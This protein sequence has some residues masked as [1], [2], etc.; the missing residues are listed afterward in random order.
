MRTLSDEEV[1]G[2][3]HSPEA[4]LSDDD[5]FGPAKPAI[6]GILERLFQGASADPMSTGAAEIMAAAKP[7]PVSVLENL[8][9]DPSAFNFKA[10]SALRRKLDDGTAAPLAPRRTY[11]EASASLP[12][13]S[14]FIDNAARIARKVLGSA[15]S[16]T[17]GV[18]R[19]IGDVTGMDS[20]ADFARTSG[21]AGQRFANQTQA[22]KTQIDGFT[23]G[24]MVQ[25]VPGALEEAAVSIGTQI[26]ALATG[27]VPAAL[28][29]MF[30]QSAGTQY[31]EI[32]DKG[33][34]IAPALV[35]AAL[36][37]GAEVIG[38]KIGGTPGTL[39]ALR[40]AIT[41][42]EPARVATEMLRAGIR[43]IPGEQLTTALQYGTDAAPVIGSNLN[44]SLREYL[45]QAKKTAVQTV[46][47]GGM[48]T[49]AG[50]ALASA[51]RLAGNSPANG[52]A[53]PA[54]NSD[55]AAKEM[56]R[57]IDAAAQGIADQSPSATP[58]QKARVMDMRPMSDAEVFGE[59]KPPDAY[60]P[61]SPAIESVADANTNQAPT[62][63]VAPAEAP[64]PN[65]TPAPVQTGNEVQTSPS[66]P[67]LQAD[68]PESITSPPNEAPNV[69]NPAPAPE[70]PTQP[71]QAIA[72]QASAAQGVIAAGPPATGTP[73]RTGAVQADGVK[74]YSKMTYEDLDQAYKDAIQS[75]DALDLEAVRKHN[76]ETAAQEFAAWS[77]GKRDA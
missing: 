35:N 52:Q 32:R 73:A 61:A 18:V 7:A 44:P 71:S 62:V 24:S 49:G 14:G 29:V 72:A 5:V 8:P 48:M 45:D 13:D 11:S 40:G 4:V 31:G 74:P 28:A 30:G 75:N 60:M 70:A 20:V 43:D 10:A 77:R 59:Q 22:G 47:Q 6:P 16:G 36:T 68:R 64:A 17:A 65:R 66:G 25:A 34:S 12:V 56:A 2:S 46:L 21:K 23:P 3:T 54:V 57:E 55:F 9:P 69:Q 50:S 19:A 37:G 42:N 41:G 53:L 67:L 51:A 33:M 63:Q 58:S 1:F 76:G 15:N 27:N 39:R 26:P 38:E